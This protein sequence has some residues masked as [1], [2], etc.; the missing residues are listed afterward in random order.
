MER[1]GH[2]A[3]ALEF[4]DVAEVD[5]H[6]AGIVLELDGLLRGYG[7]DLF[8]GLGA[9]FLDGLFQLECHRDPSPFFLLALAR[10]TTRGIRLRFSLAAGHL[11][12]IVGLMRSIR[13]RSML[14]GILRL[15]A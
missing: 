11:S 10:R 14:P 12:I 7:Q 15:A 3:V 9:Q 6:H 1:A 8:F 13:N 5:Q 4:T 2:A